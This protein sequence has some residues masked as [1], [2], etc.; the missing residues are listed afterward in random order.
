MN[1]FCAREIEAV[2]LETILYIRR[3]TGGRRSALA[4]VADAV[5]VGFLRVYLPDA[6]RHARAVTAGLCIYCHEHP[7]TNGQRCALCAATANARR[8]QEYQR[9]KA[10]GICTRPGCG[11]PNDGATIYCADH[12]LANAEKLQRLRAP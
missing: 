8:R 4:D 11:R 1:V 9:R 3:L 6:L 10:A 2:R 5:R 7:A 12:R